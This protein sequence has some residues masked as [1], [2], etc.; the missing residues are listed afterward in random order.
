M[1]ASNSIQ[2][3]L[4]VRLVACSPLVL[5]P[6][7]RLPWCLHARSSGTFEQTLAVAQ[8]QLQQQQQQQQQQVQVDSQGSSG[9]LSNPLPVPAIPTP[10][11]HNSISSTPLTGPLPVQG[12]VDMANAEVVVAPIVVHNPKEPVRPWQWWPPVSLLGFRLA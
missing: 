9:A 11:W 7:S 8:A 6:L 4:V 5:S 10:N 2:A 12:D 3:S 1:K